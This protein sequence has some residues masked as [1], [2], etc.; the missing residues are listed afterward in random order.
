MTYAFASDLLGHH[1]GEV[2][3]MKYPQL[4]RVR[5]ERHDPPLPDFNSYARRRCVANKGEVKKKDT[6]Q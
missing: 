2:S 6:L 4:I 3:A 5:G 1:E